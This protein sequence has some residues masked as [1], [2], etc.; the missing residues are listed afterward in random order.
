MKEFVES[1]YLPVSEQRKNLTPPVGRRKIFLLALL[2]RIFSTSK[3]KLLLTN[4]FLAH[5]EL[6]NRRAADRASCLGALHE[7]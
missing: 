3:L 5:G 6:M 1:D 7:D 4:H 2:P